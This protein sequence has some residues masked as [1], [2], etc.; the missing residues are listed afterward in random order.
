MSV[1]RPIKRLATHALCL[2][3]LAKEPV[4]LG[5]EVARYPLQPF[6]P[7]HTGPISQPRHNLVLD[8]FLNLFML[9]SATWSVLKEVNTHLESEA[10]SA[11]LT[12]YA[13]HSWFQT[14]NRP[15]KMRIETTGKECRGHLD[16]VWIMGFMHQTDTY[17]PGKALPTFHPVATMP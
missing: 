9:W 17:R 15:M 13:L 8:Q 2:E 12:Q 11:Y 3:F 14:P 6:K 16:G 1:F 7:H 10:A 4:G 5:Q